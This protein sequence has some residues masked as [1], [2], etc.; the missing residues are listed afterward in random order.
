[1]LHGQ[2]LSSIRITH[3]VENIGKQ[4]ACSEKIELTVEIQRSGTQIVPVQSREGKSLGRKFSLI[5]DVMKGKDGSDLFK[6]I[7]VG[8]MGF[9]ENGNKGGGPI[10][11]VN[12]IHRHLGL[13]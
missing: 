5:G 10:V 3:C 13:P 4:E 11:T 1:M 8:V 2:D 6:M 7:P 9:Q 12:H